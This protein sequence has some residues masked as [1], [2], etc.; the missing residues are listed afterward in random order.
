M[1][2][3]EEKRKYK[4]ETTKKVKCPKNPKVEI[5]WKQ[6]PWYLEPVCSFSG[7]PNCKKCIKKGDYPKK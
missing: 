1:G 4:E 6:S 2:Y 5:I 7:H 3:W